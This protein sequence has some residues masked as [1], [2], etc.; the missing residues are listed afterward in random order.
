MLHAQESQIPKIQ[1]LTEKAAVDR[2]RPQNTH[3][4]PATE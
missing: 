4:L 1:R 2:I 3:S